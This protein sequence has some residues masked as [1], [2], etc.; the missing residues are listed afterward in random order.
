MTLRHSLVVQLLD[1]RTNRVLQDLTGLVGS[2]SWTTRWRRS[3]R[4]SIRVRAADLDPGLRASLL[5]GDI[6]VYLRLDS[7]GDAGEEGQREVFSGPLT[8]LQWING[9]SLLFPSRLAERS[10]RGRRAGRW[11]CVRAKGA[12]AQQRRLATSNR[13]AR[14]CVQRA[15]TPVRRSRRSLQHHRRPRAKADGAS[16]R[17]GRVGWGGW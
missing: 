10:K 7:E 4:G 17:S 11:Y 2:V 9:S 8:S 14:A 13:L 16:P 12:A 5:V 1:R 15:S 6:S 3:G